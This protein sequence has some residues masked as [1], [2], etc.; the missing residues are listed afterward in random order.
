[1]SMT[2]F[3]VVVFGD[4]HTEVVE[5]AEDEICSFLEIDGDELD[6]R[7][8]YELLVEKDETFEAEYTYKAEV[9]ARIK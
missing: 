3:R 6:R 8:N 1:M 4:T 2:T 9:V 7:V 5:N